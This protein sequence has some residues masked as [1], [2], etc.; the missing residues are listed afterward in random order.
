VIESRNGVNIKK[1]T[2]YARKLYP[3]HEFTLLAF[4]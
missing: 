1:R 2:E 4:Q 3:E